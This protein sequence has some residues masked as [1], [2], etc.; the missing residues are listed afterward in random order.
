MVS[1]ILCPFQ[2]W[3]YGATLHR[4]AMDNFSNSQQ[5]KDTIVPWFGASDGKGR[6]SFNSHSLDY[7][8]TKVLTEW[9]QV[10]LCNR[11]VLESA[12]HPFLFSSNSISI[13]STSLCLSLSMYLSKSSLLH[14]FVLTRQWASYYNCTLGKG[15]S[16]EFP[17]G[18]ISDYLMFMA[19]NLASP[20]SRNICFTTT[21]SKPFIIFKISVRSLFSCGNS[22]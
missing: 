11:P 16:P 20:T 14:L 6:Y 13:Y 17:N 5:S 12:R 2:S 22:R 7:F 19:P 1:F 4:A 18:L 15:V 3:Q 9:K 8:C 21:L 10:I